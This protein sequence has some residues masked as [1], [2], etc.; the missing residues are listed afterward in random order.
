RAP[1]FWLGTVAPYFWHLVKRMDPEKPR[2]LLFRLL[3][4]KAQ[5]PHF[6]I[7]SHHF[8]SRAEAETPLGQERLGKCV[9]KVPVD[10]KLLPMCE[11]NAPGV[12]DRFYESIR[13]GTRSA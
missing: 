13:L 6:N 3:T 5:A 1:R 10:G 4:G 12:R 8:M 2:R 7:V 11:L 9:F